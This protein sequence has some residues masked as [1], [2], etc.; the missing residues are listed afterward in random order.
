MKTRL[1][2]SI[3]AQRRFG[4]VAL[5][6]AAVYVVLYLAAMQYL[7]IAPG[8]ARS[9]VALELLSDW[10]SLAFRQRGPFLFEPIGALQVGP[11]AVFLSIPN[12]A[13]ALGLGSL[14]G[15]N[16]AVSYYEFRQRGMRGV[17]GVHVLLATIP[18]LISGAACCFPS[19][20]GGCFAG[21]RPQA[22]ASVGLAV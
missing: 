5:A 9:L 1:L 21:W 12:L 10:R 7:V 3:L 22:L 4:V 11:L 15:A 2:R 16:V 13:I 20:C 17:R 14:V 6:S 8:P 19:A 18:A